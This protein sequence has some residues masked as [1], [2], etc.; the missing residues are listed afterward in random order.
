MCASACWAKPVAWLQGRLDSLPLR[1]GCALGGA[2]TDGREARRREVRSARSQAVSTGRAWVGAGS[3]RRF[4][5][6]LGHEKATNLEMG[7]LALRSGRSAASEKKLFCS[8]FREWRD[9]DSN[10][11]HHD[12]QGAVDHTRARRKACNSTYSRRAIPYVIPLVW[13][14]LPRVWDSAGAL[15]SQM[16]GQASASA[17][18]ASDGRRTPELEI[19]RA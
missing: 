6:G 1:R 11:G 13:F 8:V 2:G 3:L 16:S 14:G 17:P 4:R 10:R 19:S 12:F 7:A 9:P 5:R 18:R 15:K